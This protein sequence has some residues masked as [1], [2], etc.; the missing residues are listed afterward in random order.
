MA[1]AHQKTVEVTACCFFQVL[2]VTYFLV[3]TEAH[4]ALITNCSGEYIYSKQAQLSIF[5]KSSLIAPQ[6]PL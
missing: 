6:I 5:S 2:V 3:G 1:K 4:R